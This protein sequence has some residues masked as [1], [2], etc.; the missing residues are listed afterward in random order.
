MCATHRDLTEAVAAGR[1]RQDLYFRIAGWESRVPPLRERA[2]DIPPM[3]NRFLAE[4]G[5]DQGIDP[6]TERA[7][8]AHSFPGNVRELRQLK[9][10][11]AVKHCGASRISVGDLP[12]SWHAGKRVN[13]LIDSA[14]AVAARPKIEDQIIRDWVRASVGLRDIAQRAGDIAIAEALALESNQVGRAARRL[15]ITERAIQLRKAQ[16]STPAAI[17]AD[18]AKNPQ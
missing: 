17:A 12:I 18:A 15:G 16:R 11:T 2:E 7:L 8:A 5:C 3:A 1:F 6:H 14:C 10:Q 13:P 4:F 9:M